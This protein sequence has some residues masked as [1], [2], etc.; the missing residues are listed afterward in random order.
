MS[1]GS[2]FCRR[3]EAYIRKAMRGRSEVERLEMDSCPGRIQTFRLC[4]C[5]DNSP[6]GTHIEPL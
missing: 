6:D 5:L 2:L 3:G 4:D 1:S